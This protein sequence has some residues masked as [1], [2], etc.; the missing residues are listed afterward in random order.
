MLASHLREAID[1]DGFAILPGVFSAW[2]VESAVAELDGI[3]CRGNDAVRSRAGTV[4]AAR[5]VLDLWP[6][7]GDIWRRA[8]LGEALA[9]ILGPDY[10]L[11]RV[12]FFDK[13]PGQTWSLPL[14]RDRTIAV[15]NNALSSIQFTKP[16]RKA[17]VPHVQAPTSVLLGMLTARIH[18]D[19][20]THENGPLHVIPGSHSSGKALPSAGSAKLVL[21]RRGDVLLMRPLLVHGSSAS[22]SATSRH[23]RILH[24]EFTGSPTLPD[25]YEWHD[26]VPY[27]RR[28]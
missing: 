11:V 7:A 22:Q 15:R 16:T 2:E 12:L 18:L 17:G 27:R 28:P 6:A 8:P 3:L 5:N 1:R 23:R 10:G 13:P 25:R 9:I 20:V 26:F 14:H 21:A 19:D 4:Y 24:L